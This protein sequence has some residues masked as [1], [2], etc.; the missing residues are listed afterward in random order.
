MGTYVGIKLRNLKTFQNGSIIYNYTNDA[1]N[2]SCQHLCKQLVGGH[3]FEAY[4]CITISFLCPWN[5]GM[6]HL[7]QG[8]LPYLVWEVA[9]YDQGS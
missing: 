3:N 9:I 6:A 2:S 7:S 4:I 8:K 1:D 5:L